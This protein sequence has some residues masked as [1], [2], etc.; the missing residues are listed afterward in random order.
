V[1]YIQASGAIFIMLF[2]GLVLLVLSG[3]FYAA[4]ERQLGSLG[5]TVCNMGPI[6]CQHPSWLLIGAAVVM[7]WAFF[8]R[9]D[10]L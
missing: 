3:I 4:G 7:V 10:M 9:V 2:A 5:D 6:F 8:L 1:E